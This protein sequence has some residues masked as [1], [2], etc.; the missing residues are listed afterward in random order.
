MQKILKTILLV[1]GLILSASSFA[2]TNWQAHHPRRVDVNHRLANQNS[3]INHKVVEGKM[4]PY[5]ARHLRH[6]DH[7]IRQE[8]R[9]D[10]KFNHSHITKTE[11]NT[12]NHQENQVSHQIKNQ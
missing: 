11:Q 10:S 5:Q 9:T 7:L 3:S 8:E 12:L 4:T 2:Q 6:E 1:G